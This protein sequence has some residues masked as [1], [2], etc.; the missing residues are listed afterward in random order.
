MNSESAS[1]VQAAL[2]APE[3]IDWKIMHAVRNNRPLLQFSSLRLCLPIVLLLAAC[4][5]QPPSEPGAPSVEPSPSPQQAVEPAEYS[6]LRA[7]TSAQDKLYRVAAPILVNNAELC[8]GNARNLLGFTAKNK[9][10][11][12]IELASAAESLL[13]LDERLQV[14][15]VLSG[16]GA[17][18]AGVQPGDKLLSIESSA[19][20]T[21]LNAER[22][23]AAILLPLMKNRSGVKLNVLRNDA[24][25]TLTVPLTYD[26]A[27]G[28][29]LGNADHVNA[30]NDG[31]RVMLTRGMLN[32]VQSETEL[33]YVLAKELAHNS[34]RHASKQ[35][36]VGTVSAVI[37]NLVRIEPDLRSMA[38]SAGIK[39]MPQEL[40]AEADRLALYML[41]RAGYNIDGAAHFWRRLATQYPA[42]VL[43]SYTA[44]HPGT[45]LRL[46]MIEKTATEIKNKQA[47]K[48]PLL[49]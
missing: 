6:K 38:G 12:S 23:A 11:Y 43:N 5:T 19:V 14:M 47:M 10:S 40:D 36:V 24:E 1:A 46:T 45:A 48:R 7:L 16:S 28:V 42:T 39:A 29:E 18:R 17:A 30:Y 34:L 31:R 2:A 21:G 27:F 41:A 3:N 32:F 26:C 9:Y 20:P 13:G 8:K 44:I 15:G 49:P 37:E 25:I 35:N 33:A 22:Q 4:A